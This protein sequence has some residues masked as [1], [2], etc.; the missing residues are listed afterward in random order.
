MH[1]KNWKNHL[2]KLLT[3]AEIPSFQKFL[4]YCPTAQMAEVMV[5][6]LAYRATVYRTGVQ[7]KT[8]KSHSEIIWHLHN[9][10]FVVRLDID[11][12]ILLQ[13]N[14]S[15]SIISIFRKSLLFSTRIWTEIDLHE[16][17]YVLLTD[18]Y[19]ITV[20]FVD[21]MMKKGKFWKSWT[22]PRKKGRISMH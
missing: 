11:Q 1:S 22:F 19:N 21:K 15:I 9:S 10:Q 7:M 2:K 18:V 20:K 3:L 12:K 5:Q 4:F 8:S 16:S 17:K 14:E 6:N 13:C